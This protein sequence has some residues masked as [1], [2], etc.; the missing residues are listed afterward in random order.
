MTPPS[1]HS[2]GETF[3]AEV[4]GLDLRA[5]IAAET[6]AGINQALLDNLVLAIRDQDLLEQ[7]IRPENTLGDVVICDNRCAMHRADPDY[8]QAEE[9]LPWRIILKGDRPV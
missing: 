8:N 1:I 4:V 7:A 9:R 6:A 2:L 3:G 5:P